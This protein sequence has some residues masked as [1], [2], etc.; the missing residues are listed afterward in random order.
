MAASH[1]NE[2]VRYEPNDTP[3]HAIALGA[4]FQAAMLIVALVV[5]TVVHSSPDRRSA[6]FL[7]RL[8]HLCGAA[9]RGVTTTLQAVRFG[10]IG[11]GH[12]LIMGTSGA[13]IAVCVAALVEGGPS[14]MASLV[15]ISSLF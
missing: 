15:V 5:L 8:G 11:S 6:W 12:V 7:C 10:G 1:T 2:N 3:P 4:G 9:G 13:F 14:T